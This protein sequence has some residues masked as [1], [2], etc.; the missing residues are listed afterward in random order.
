[1]SPTVRNQKHSLSLKDFPKE[2][3]SFQGKTA[4]YQ[5][6]KLLGKG[7]FGVVF[8]VQSSIDNKMYAAKLESYNHSRKVLLMD[9]LVL[10]G[11]EILK[12]VHFCK[13]FELGKVEG[14]FRFIIITMLGPSLHMLRTSQARNHFSLGTALRFAQQ[15]LE[16]L[17]DMHSIGF[18]HRDVKPSNFG[19][20]RPETNDF[21][22][23]Y[24]F[25]FGLA[26]QFATVNKDCRLPRKSAPFRGT[27]RYASLNSHR[28]R[29][30]SPKDDIES[31]FYMVIEW[32]V[33]ALPWKNFKN[34]DHDKIMLMKERS[35]ESNGVDLLLEGCPLPHYRIIMQYIDDL[36]YT[37]IPDYGY[38]YFLLKHIAK[39]NQISPDEP[40]DHDPQ[41]PYTGTETPPSCLPYGVLISPTH[42]KGI[43]E[44]SGKR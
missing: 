36:Q 30:Q 43:I 37:S 20:G 44:D 17:Q 6:I 5:V 33:G 39:R 23:V 12:S 22:I 8:Q 26:R 15:T 7:G 11:A 32:T 38:I 28:K 42:P 25:D 18:L 2:G 27:P 31:W 19:V 9:C 10:R 3:S 29:E 24:I 16:A 14:K 21:H 40:L 41:H 35:R 34:Q 13:I 1:M 4:N